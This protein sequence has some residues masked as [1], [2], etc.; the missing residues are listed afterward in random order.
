MQKP[1][2][3]CIQETKLSKN[4]KTL[5]SIQGYSPGYFQHRTEGRGG[6]LAIFINNILPSATVIPITSRD[7]SNSQIEIQSLLVHTGKSELQIFN[8]YDPGRNT[9]LNHQLALKKLTKCIKSKLT[10]IC[11]DFNAHNELWGGRVTDGRG[12]WVETMATES[13]LTILND[14]AKTRLNPVDGT[15]FA[16]DLTLCTPRLAQ[17][18]EWGVD[19]SANGCTIRIK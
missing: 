11:G 17:V 13:T 1:D 2:I 3:L 8:V 10:I 7:I 18:A 12:K 9:K 15:L 16:M 4:S 19:Q 6:G 14:G 5:P